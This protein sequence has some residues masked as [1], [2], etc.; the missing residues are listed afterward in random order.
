MG[1]DMIREIRTRINQVFVGK[2]DV[3]E[4]VLICLLSGG[5]VLL[6]DVPGVG[7]T[8]LAKTV[9]RSVDCS[10]A[11][12]QF[13]PDTLPGD[14][15][16]LS[17]YNMKTGDFEYKEGVIMHNMILA[18]EINRTSPKTQACLLE[19][20]G[21]GR[22]TVDGKSY[23]L[24]DP[25]MVIATQNPVEYLGTYPLP[26]AQTDRFMMKLTI[27]YP[28][29]D[30]EIHMIRNHLDKKNVDSIQPA[31]TG[32]DIIRLKKQV[33]EVHVSDPILQYVRDIISNTRQESRLV[34][35]AS[36][37]AMLSLVSAARAGAFLDGRDFVKPDD[38]KSLAVPVLR[39]RLS[40]TSEARI[41]KEDMDNIIRSLVLKAKVPME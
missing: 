33:E 7:K 14:V 5:H 22:V 32:D 31:C 41:R 34:I 13:T 27:G 17:V 2:E 10:F 37:R 29:A 12:I 9:A 36:P 6:E 19:A 23:E 39:H 26:E 11:R 4:L 25:F 3:V 16:G 38:V 18:D 30:Q 24:P 35:G 28:D 21:E 1:R 20:M 8:T 40:L 15:T